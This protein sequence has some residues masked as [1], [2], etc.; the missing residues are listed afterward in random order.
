[1]KPGAF[2]LVVTVS[3]GLLV[4]PLA[5]E[6]QQAGKLPRIGFLS[7][8]FLREED[9]V[10]APFLQS[11]R[12]LGYAEGQNIAIEYRSAERRLQRLP[13]LAAALVRLEV[14]ILVAVAPPAIH[15]ARDATT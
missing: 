12:G 1:M 14:S 11:L 13:D 5:V 4:A 8:L 9:P 3:L 6:A 15:A 10:F 2:G 7:P